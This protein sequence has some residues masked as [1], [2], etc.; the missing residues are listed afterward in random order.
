VH[1]ALD[2]K[3]RYLTREEI[4]SHISLH[5]KHPEPRLFILQAPS[6]SY[7]QPHCQHPPRMRRRNNAI[8][9]KP[10]RRIDRLAFAFDPSLQLRIHGLAD[11]LHDRAQLLRA[12][13]ADLGLWPHPE[14]ARGVGASTVVAKSAPMLR[15]VEWSYVERGG[16]LPHPII[17]RAGASTYDD[18]EFGHVGTR[19]CGD[20][21][22][23]VLGYAALFGVGADHEAADVLEE[24]GWYTS[25][26][27][28]LDEVCAFER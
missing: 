26:S 13:D 12:H 6:H 14:E 16:S 8:I 22:G 21:L 2:C 15:G 7:L 1:V 17:T 10:R 23:A 28:E 4:P 11:R 19:N 24:D 3:S 9:P 5:P 20:E 27:T 25:L 18:S